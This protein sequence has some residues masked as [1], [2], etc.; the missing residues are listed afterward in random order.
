MK[1]QWLWYVQ[2][3]RKMGH[4][5]GQQNAEDEHW[6][7]TE[8]PL[9]CEVPKAFDAGHMREDKSA[10]EKESRTPKYPPWT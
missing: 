3:I 5:A 1:P 6:R 7:Y 2:A 10:Y 4:G 9:H 8:Y